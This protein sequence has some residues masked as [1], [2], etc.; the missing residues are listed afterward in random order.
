MKYT[1]LPFQVSHPICPLDS[2]HFFSDFEFPT[3]PRDERRWK[4]TSQVAQLQSK[5]QRDQRRV[6]RIQENQGCQYHY[7]Y[8]DRCHF[9]KKE[10]FYL[11][12]KE[13]FKKH[14]CYLFFKV[15]LC[16]E[17][18]LGAIVVLHVL[19]SSISTDFL[20]YEVVRAVILVVNMMI[21]LSYP[22][23]FGIYCGMSKQFRDTFTELFI[24]RVTRRNSMQ[25]VSVCLKLADIDDM[26]WKN[27][28]QWYAK[29]ILLAQSV[30]HR[31]HDGR[32]FTQCKHLNLLARLLLQ[33]SIFCWF[34]C[35]KE[36]AIFESFTRI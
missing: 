4:E 25:M 31:R 24:K 23:N 34:F 10:H 18:P 16:V 14:F 15:F 35:I 27:V 17:V 7:T 26:T 3:F 8:A 1:F 36:K 33:S 29:W 12:F 6:Q 19:S 21:S 28:Y 2:L 13:P 32:C 9:C 30:S 5:S 20:N 22:L 11:I